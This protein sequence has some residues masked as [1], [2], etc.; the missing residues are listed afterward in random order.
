[1]LERQCPE[2]STAFNDRTRLRVAVEVEKINCPALC[3]AAGRDWPI[4]HPPGQDAGVGEFYGAQNVNL[5]EAA[6]N[7]MIDIE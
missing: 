4:T 6:D 5:A 1:M 2:S 7:L 3:I